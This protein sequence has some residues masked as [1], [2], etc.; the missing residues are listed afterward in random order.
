MSNPTA[1]MLVIGDEILS[2]RTRDANMYHLAG[3][4]SE[5]G[6]DLREVRI[7]PDVPEVIV[8]ALDALRS[9]YTHV[10]TSGG[11]G[12][13]HDDITADC[14]ARAF[15]VGIGVRDDARAILV[16]HYPNG[17]ADLNEARL[18]MA[19]IPDGATLIENP[20]S[21]AP[22]FSI[23]NVH[24]MAGVPSVFTAMVESLLP[25]LTG[26]APLM[27]ENVRIDRG[28]GDSAGPLAE[29]DA[30]FPQVSIGS[31]PFQRDGRFAVNIVL[32]SSDRAALDAA[33]NDVRALTE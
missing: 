17:E 16:S 3:K 30:R 24:V 25:G 28:E 12:P 11:I 10:F 19:R 20:V 9:R 21:K 7:V 14:V 4:L 13:T 15:G 33:T 23:G 5:K 18:R 32:R 2:G 27:T 31:Y 22:G 26:G 6:I 1:A 29:I 8:E